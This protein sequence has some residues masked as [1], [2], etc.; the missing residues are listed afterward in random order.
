MK[1]RKVAALLLLVVVATVTGCGCT[2]SLN[3][4]TYGSM[5]MLDPLRP[6]TGRN[7]A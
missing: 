2:P 7:S 6:K 5:Q 3:T 4:A 1:V